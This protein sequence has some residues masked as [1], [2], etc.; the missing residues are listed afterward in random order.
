MT[1]RKTNS[2]DSDA[3]RGLL[4]DLGEI[5]A[6]LQALHQQAAEALAPTVWEILRTESRDSRLIEHTLDHLLDHACIPEGLDL[7]KSICRHYWQ[8]NPQVTASYIH[9]YRE[10]WDSEDREAQNHSHNP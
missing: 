4:D 7:F 6:P 2:L 10:M 8:I 9:A 3:Y 1:T 5:I